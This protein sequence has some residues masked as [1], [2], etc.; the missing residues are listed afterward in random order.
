MDA[1]PDVHGSVQAQPGAEVATHQVGDHAK[2]FVEQKQRRDLQWAVAQRMKVQHHQH[3]QGAV[4]EG[5]G[6]VV[7][8]NEQILPH[9]RREG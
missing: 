1:Q 3:A 4:G 7:A 8:R 2:E 5:E 6:P 9:F